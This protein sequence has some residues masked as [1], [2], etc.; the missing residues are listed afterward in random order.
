MPE[1]YI[2]SAW[3]QTERVLIFAA[4]L[5]QSHT[6]MYTNHIACDLIEWTDEDDAERQSI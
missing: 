3:D 1:Y 2:V 6:H 4:I 5:C